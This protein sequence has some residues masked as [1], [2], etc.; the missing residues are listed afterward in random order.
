MH[1]SRSVSALAVIS[2]F[3]TSAFRES[4]MTQNRKRIGCIVQIQVNKRIE[5]TGF[6]VGPNMILTCAHVVDGTLTTPLTKSKSKAKADSGIEVVFY[7]QS[8]SEGFKAIKPACVAKKHSTYWSEYSDTLDDDKLDIGI[9]TFEGGLPGGVSIAEF[10]EVEFPQGKT[11]CTAGFPGRGIL[12]F[13]Q[14][15][16]IDNSISVGDQVLW[17]LTG[18]RLARGYSGAPLIDPE[19]GA[20]FGMVCG[21]PD[22]D[23]VDGRAFAIPLKTLRRVCPDLKTADPEASRK[24]ERLRKRSRQLKGLIVTLLGKSHLV[25]G[26]LW[27]CHP[28][29]P[30]GTADS[31]DRQNSLL[32]YTEQLLDRSRTDRTQLVA[33]LIN[34]KEQFEAESKSEEVRTLTALYHC[35]APACVDLDTAITALAKLG[36]ELP[37][38]ALPVCESLTL[39]ELIMAAL[40][41]R[42]ALFRPTSSADEPLRPQ[43]MLQEPLE[44]GF[45]VPSKPQA[46]VNNLIEAICQSIAQV[47]PET[48]Q[49]LCLEATSTDARLKELATDLELLHLTGKTLFLDVEA[50]KNGALTADDV[51]L[52]RTCL[53]YLML[54]KIGS[55]PSGDVLSLPDAAILTS[56]FRN[57]NFE[58]RSAPGPA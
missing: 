43:Y 46:A 4:L 13:Q 25:A 50:Q 22:H 30:V 10:H 9:L 28:P 44:T 27:S 15:A 14:S 11:F 1:N 29:L 37:P 5:G 41:G 17:Q 21:V 38:E 47:P 36:V 34:L 31:W 33:N 56:P 8:D 53:P 48:L 16:I 55:A 19:T 57:R 24:S 26:C 49:K 3:G 7:P 20:V 12:D 51:A 45:S 2:G 52:I 32:R 35:F 54:V 40:D 39:F 6:V 23:A 42:K 18:T 58:P